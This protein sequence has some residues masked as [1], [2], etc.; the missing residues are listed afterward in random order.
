MVKRFATKI[1]RAGIERNRERAQK[2]SGTGGTELDFEGFR[3]GTAPQIL[4][5]QISPKCWRRGRIKLS[6]KERFGRE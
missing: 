3:A 4:T 2:I 6:E 1:L 5:A